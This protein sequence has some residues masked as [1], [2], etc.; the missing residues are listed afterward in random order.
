MEWTRVKIYT[1]H[2]GVEPVI[3]ELLELGVIGFEV[4]DA[5]DFSEFLRTE[6]PRWDFV[7][8][9]LSYLLECETNL[10]IYLA[11]TAQGHE[12]LVLLRGALER[13]RARDTESSFG[14]L[15]LKCEG[16]NEE[17]W[18]NNWKQ[19]FHNTPIGEKLMI[20]PT[21]ESLNGDEAGS[22]AVLEIDP[23]ASFGTGTHDTTR[24]CMELI[25]ETVTGGEELLDMGCGSGILGIAAMLLG[26]ARVTAADIDENSVRIARENFLQNHIDESALRFFCGDAGESRELYEKITDR[27]YD[28]VVANIVADVILHLLPLLVECM[29]K[30]GTLLLSGIIE[31][32]EGDIMAALGD[33]GLHAKNRKESGGWVALRAGKSF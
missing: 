8:E 5:A 9:S 28:I 25:E 31:G 24:L 29:N 21:W 17:D 4:E 26:A 14:R 10:T 13:L 33:I 20:K 12:Q 7:D 15:A 22:R 6:T 18:A 19:Y 11:D 1:T 32:R 23:A 30:N 27:K 16:I 2:E 3:G